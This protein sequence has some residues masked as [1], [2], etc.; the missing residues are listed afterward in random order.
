MENRI[1]RFEAEVDELKTLSLDPTLES[2]CRR[3]A[4]QQCAIAKAKMNLLR[5]DRIDTRQRIAESVVGKPQASATRCCEARHTHDSEDDDLSAGDDAEFEEIRLARLKELHFQAVKRSELTQ[6]GCGLVTTVSE[7]GMKAILS[8]S[9]TPHVV[10]H[11]IIEGDSIGAEVSEFL[12]NMARTYLG[13]R[14][15]RCPICPNSQFPARMGLGYP[16]G[17]IYFLDGVVKKVMPLS[18]LEDYDADEGALETKFRKAG[19]FL[20][21]DEAIESR[22]SQ[23]D[24]RNDVLRVDD[25]SDEDKCSDDGWEEPCEICGRRYPHRHVRTMYHEHYSSD[26]E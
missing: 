15:V 25:H 13:T 4:E 14:F 22:S 3:D 26:N 8:E 18:S 19:A 11:V 12:D 5:Q 17:I 7:S 21:L 6:S 16:S 23:K 9:P 2:C 1:A 24:C 20:T 10:C